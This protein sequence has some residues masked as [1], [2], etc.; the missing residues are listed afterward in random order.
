MHAMKTV[1][2]PTDFSEHSDSAFRAACSLAEDH[3]ARLILLHVMPPAVAPTLSVPP[4]D[5]LEAAESQGHLTFAFPWPQPPSLGLRVEHRVAEGD[6]PEEILRLAQAEDCDLIVMGTHGRTGLGRLLTGSVAEEVLR[7]ARCPVMVVKAAAPGDGRS[8]ARRPAQPGEV[9]SVRPLGAALA[10]A[11]TAGLV[12]ANGI[13]VTRLV[14]PA[15][16]ELTERKARGTTVLHCLEGRV[17]F[18][19][20][21]KL[22][23]LEPGELAY[24]PAGETYTIKGLEDA[25][26]LRTVALPKG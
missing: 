5:P 23:F 16:D 25:S 17:A 4:P 9:V 8:G 6:A 10:S 2:H 26:L 22:Q 19:A 21:G 18:T 12:R 13:D 24:V 3:G 1:L 15:G 14:V 20:F 11:R 7:K